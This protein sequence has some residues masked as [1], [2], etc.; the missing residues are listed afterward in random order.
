MLLVVC[1]VLFEAR[2]V[3]VVVGL[4]DGYVKVI[5]DDWLLSGVCCL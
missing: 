2:C 5:V 3:L 4:F 1:C